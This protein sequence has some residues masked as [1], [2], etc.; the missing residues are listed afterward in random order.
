MDV[1]PTEDRVRLDASHALPRTVWRQLSCS[2]R[3]GR[4]SCDVFLNCKS[5][6]LPHVNAKANNNLSSV[7]R[8]SLS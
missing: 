6:W 7:A 2:D 5:L 3:N 8:R 1:Y 4:L